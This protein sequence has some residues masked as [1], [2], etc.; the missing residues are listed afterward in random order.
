MN[1]E[2][3]AGRKANDGYLD[4]RRICILDFDT[5]NLRVIPAEQH[6]QINL[7]VRDMIAKGGN[8]CPSNR[9]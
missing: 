6:K 8:V 2:A 1:V 7:S 9:E 3:P 5:W 4:E